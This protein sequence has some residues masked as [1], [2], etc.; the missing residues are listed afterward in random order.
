MSYPDPINFLL[1]SMPELKE[2]LESE[3]SDNLVEVVEETGDD[4]EVNQLADELQETELDES[5]VVEKPVK[6][7]RKKKK[8][9]SLIF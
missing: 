7:G 4:E 2:D 3:N 8:H 6:K 5:E 1:L 9:S